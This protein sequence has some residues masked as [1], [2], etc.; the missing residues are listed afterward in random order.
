M[1]SETR[2]CQNCKS[3]FTVEL[4][5]FRFY[6][7][8]NVP[9]PTFCP[10]CRSMRRM[11]HRNDY[12]FYKRTCDKC[13]TDI[14]SLYSSDKSIPIYCQ[15][16]WWGDGWDAKEYGKEF[17]FSKS[18]FSQFKELCDVV[19]AL[20]ILNDNG[21]MSENCQYTNYFALGKDCY[22]TINSWKVENCMYSSCLS[23]PKDVVDSMILYSDSQQIYSSVDVDVSYKCRNIY[24]CASLT[25]CSFCFD[26]RGCSDCFM[27]V[28][29]RNKS[30][31]FKNKEYSK[32]EYLATLQNY[33]L[34]TFTGSELAEAEFNDFRLTLPHRP[35]FLKNCTDCTGQYLVNSKN[36]KNCFIVINIED[37]KF[38][39]R[40]D[41]IRDS[42]D[43]LSGGQQELCY[44]SINPDNSSRSAFTTYCHKD[45]DAYYCDGCQSCQD[46]FGCVG[47]K[48]AQY[49]IF[50]K[51]Y[52]KDEYFSL[53]RKIVDHMIGTKEWGEFFPVEC[54]PFCY[55]ETLAQDEF[56]LT[57]DEAYSKGYTWQDNIPVTSGKETIKDIPDSV[58]NIPD[59]FTNEIL[60]CE[61][62]N[63]N[64]KII[65]R[66][67]R[68]YRMNGIPIPHACFFCRTADLYAKRGPLRLWE[69]SCMCESTEHDHAGK[70]INGF[71]TNYAPDRPE[72]VYCE[73]CYQKEV[74]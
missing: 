71:E 5:D 47:L 55:N 52:S 62:C 17:D 37:S 38:F 59:S 15:K 31:C 44:E 57:R 28:G 23:G 9:S 74:V 58:H 24:H 60:A 27:C 66:E 21:S 48:S 73:S 7:K 61:R 39:E 19:P 36:S 40:G 6:E 56:P 34:D 1:T 8:M 45:V 72:I 29:L 20:A 2:T 11:S 10:E 26:C 46:V 43:C 42:Y 35:F 50:N 14:I 67:L 63:R 16:C 30:Y 41:T 25:N 51:Q 70:C 69:R 3:I 13:A 22:L 32:E 64:Y 18:F 4:E 33:K 53:R 54:S 12:C 65:D 68:F 49:C